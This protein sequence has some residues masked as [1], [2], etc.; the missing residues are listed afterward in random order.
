MAYDS[1]NQ[2]AK[3]YFMTIVNKKQKHSETKLDGCP[4]K[5]VWTIVV[6]SKHEDC[7]LMLTKPRYVV[8]RLD[9]VPYICTFVQYDGTFGAPDQG[10][11]LDVWESQTTESGLRN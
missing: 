4:K 7:N 2:T 5:M 8:S 9:I 11:M 1:V 3:S 10:Q 6:T